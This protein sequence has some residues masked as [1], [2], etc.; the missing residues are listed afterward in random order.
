MLPLIKYSTNNSTAYSA[1][2]RD[3]PCF[4]SF[5]LGQGYQEVETPISLRTHQGQVGAREKRGK[6]FLVCQKGFLV[7]FG[8]GD[9][10]GQGELGAFPYLCLLPL[11]QTPSL[12]C[13]EIGTVYLFF[14]RHHQKQCPLKGNDGRNPARWQ[15][16]EVSCAFQSCRDSVCGW[17][18]PAG[19]SWTP[20][21]PEA[22]WSP[23]WW[24]KA[25]TRQMENTRSSSG[26]GRWPLAWMVEAGEWVGAGG[27]SDFSTLSCWVAECSFCSS[28]L[29]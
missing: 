3:W 20:G 25:H 21:D 11:F 10:P 7:W 23:K 5:Y 24:Q 13:G 22:T 1:A 26:S 15:L 29:L 19:R 18:W 28:F 8:E 16:T 4:W 27:V 14:S 17:L 12:P 6:A 2:T 9:P